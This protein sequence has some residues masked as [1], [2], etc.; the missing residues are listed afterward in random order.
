MYRLGDNASLLKLDER[1]DNSI[2]CISGYQATDW[3]LCVASGNSV[4]P[5]WGVCDQRTVKFVSVFVSEWESENAHTWQWSS[6]E[7]SPSPELKVPKSIAY[8]YSGCL[9]RVCHKRNLLHRKCF[10]LLFNGKLSESWSVSTFAIFVAT[11]GKPRAMFEMR[12]LS[13][14]LKA[15]DSSK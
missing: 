15:Q 3:M 9:F 14:G 5:E 1:K 6:L 7:T 4:W 8:F 2:H 13:V 10:L 12:A 11:L